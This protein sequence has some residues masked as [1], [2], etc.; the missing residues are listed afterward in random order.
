M[1][2]FGFERLT[3]LQNLLRRMSNQSA[4]RDFATLLLIWRIWT[5]TS[6]EGHARRGPGGYPRLG[7]YFFSASAFV[8]GVRCHRVADARVGALA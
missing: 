8:I 2:Q 4:M 1:T 6:P 3:V 5:V 7:G